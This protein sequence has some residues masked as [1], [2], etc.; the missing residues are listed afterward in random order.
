MNK[1]ASLELSINAIVILI[2]AITMLGLGLGFM[3]NI[4][5]SATDQF[6]QVTGAVEKQ[7]ID[8]MKEGNKIVDLS[9]PKL[10]IKKGKQEQIFIGFRN[11]KDAINYYLIV[12]P[13]E[14]SGNHI[15][16]V[17]I[18]KAECQA[19]LEIGYKQDPT[20]VQKGDVV[21]L[22]INIKAEPDAAQ[23]TCFI[24]VEVCVDE[25]SNQLI[26][27]GTAAF[28]TMN[29]CKT[30]SVTVSAPS[31]LDDVQHLQLVVDVTV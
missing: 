30:G 19:A 14:S 28:N 17:G 16:G 15:D 11:V 20:S 1:K 23:G 27:A 26:A 18:T 10:T 21:V 29:G 2:L 4:F 6:R 7:M 9:R 12:N 25:D 13:E 22:P 31:D 24:D 5:G 3:R 8:Q